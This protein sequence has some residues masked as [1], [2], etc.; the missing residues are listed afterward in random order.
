MRQEQR[1]ELIKE[2]GIVGALSEYAST[3][4]DKNDITGSIAKIATNTIL[5][6]YL[7]IPWAIFGAILQY[8]FDIDVSDIISKLVTVLVDFFK[9]NGDK[10]VNPDATA[11]ELADKTIKDAGLSDT[12]LEQPI[13]DEV[14]NASGAYSNNNLVK[15]GGAIGFAASWLGKT[16]G[17]FI[18]KILVTIIKSIILG[19]GIGIVGAGVASGIRGTQSPTT[20]ATPA[21]QPVAGQPA[22]GQPAVDQPR[23][24]IL[25][26]VGSP[27]GYG[28]EPHLNDADKDDVGTN[29]WYA[30]NDQGDFARTI[31]SWLF[32]IYP[33]MRQAVAMAIQKNYLRAVAPVMQ[34]I[35]QF[36]DDMNANLVRI[37][38]KINNKPMTSK[39][40][41]VDAVL[42]LMIVQ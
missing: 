20:P 14:L 2:A 41:V 15:E 4:F 24:N 8:G 40:D 35:A 3:V 42:G 28:M 1:I 10:P 34:T 19:G 33:N 11:E 17:G 30:P 38:N 21:G 29:A 37:P 12:Q 23:T 31:W 9:G 7:G 13:T 22:T 16:Q 39:K 18:K 32:K 26:Y 25:N 36:N 6:Y 27:S 5:A